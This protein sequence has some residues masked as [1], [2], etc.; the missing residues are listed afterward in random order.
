MT[1][2][3]SITSNSTAQKTTDVESGQLQ[4]KWKLERIEVK[5]KP[6]H[7]RVDKPLKYIPPHSGK[8]DGFQALQALHTSPG[9]GNILSQEVLIEYAIPPELLEMANKI[10]IDDE[11]PVMVD[12]Y[13]MHRKETVPV[14]IKLFNEKYAPQMNESARR[15]DQ[16]KIDFRNYASVRQSDIDQLYAILQRVS[17]LTFMTLPVFTGGTLSNS[18][19][20]S[21][22]NCLR[23]IGLTAFSSRVESLFALRNYCCAEVHC[24]KSYSKDR[25]ML[26]ER[27]IKTKALNVVSNGVLRHQ[28]KQLERAEMVCS[29]KTEAGSNF[30]V[31]EKI[32]KMLN[33]SLKITKTATRVVTWE[34]TSDK[35]LCSCNALVHRGMPCM[36]IAFVA[37]LKNI[38]IP[39]SCFH[40]RFCYLE[41]VISSEPVPPDAPRS[42]P[43]TPMYPQEKNGR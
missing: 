35:V 28:A 30:T 3:D 1:T 14:D 27:Y 36:H 31:L 9:L 2:V 5:K 39:K 12:K 38:Q 17:D 4:P 6:K 21:I 29:L 41:Q 43:D 34:N 40:D 25:K 15:P 18:Y 10:Y 32:E 13:K 24:I 33:K 8:V 26:L 42:P 23:K 20:E 7:I 37:K 16:L 19:T 11:L 22:N